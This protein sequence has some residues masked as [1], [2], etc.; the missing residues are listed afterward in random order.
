MA[1]KI[2]ALKGHL[3]ELTAKEHKVNVDYHAID[4]AARQMTKLREESAA[5][6]ALARARTTDQEKRDKAFKEAIVEHAGGGDAESGAEKVKKAAAAAL[7]ATGE[8]KALIPGI[9]VAEAK[10]ADLAQAQK[11]LHEAG[12]EKGMAIVLD[13]IK[14]LEQEIKELDAKNEVAMMGGVD[15][16]GKETPGVAGGLALPGEKNRAKLAGLVKAQP[17]AFKG[18]GI[19]PKDFG[20]A[21]GDADPKAIA[22]AEDNERWLKQH[23]EDRNR[24]DAE[25]KEATD[26]NR[27]K[28][29]K[30]AGQFAGLGKA[31]APRLLEGIAAGAA[32]PEILDKYAGALGDLL[33]GKFKAT[34][35]G[36]DTVARLILKGE[37]GQLRGQVAAKQSEAAVEHGVDLPEA[38]AAAQLAAAEKKRKEDQLIA[39]LDKVGP[40]R[41]DQVA[42]QKAAVGKAVGTFGPALA[43]PAEQGLAAGRDEAT[44][45]ADLERR[46][47]ATGK[48]APEVVA[49]A[50]AKILEK[51]KA[52]FAGAVQRAA[53]A[54]AADP[55]GAAGRDLAAA[56]R[57]RELQGSRSQPGIESYR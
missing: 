2:K 20:G 7:K 25:R 53:E 41:N 3:K 29:A 13:N 37:L 6:D 16:A 40:N 27:A 1:E 35:K 32:D 8:D 49:D 36:L 33:R 47:R 56:E 21:L 10:R 50:A 34:D 30:Y 55:A 52:D 17:G 57:H 19:D 22:E 12:S 54:G 24:D 51:A 44:L 28:A 14:R 39:R 23:E 26:R 31:V 11:D 46:L 18:A 43:G 38:A 15:A 5:F 45:R 4:D 48:V 9:G 42:A